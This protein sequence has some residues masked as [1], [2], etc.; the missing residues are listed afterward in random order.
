MRHSF[1]KQVLART[2]RNEP[3]S[4]N[5]SSRTCV[6]THVSYV[7]LDF[8]DGVQGKGAVALPLPSDLEAV[9]AATTMPDAL[10]SS[11]SAV[12]GSIVQQL[13]RS[14]R[15]LGSLP[16]CGSESTVPCMVNLSVA[17]RAR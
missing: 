12:G 5:Y 4:T 15:S 17:S 10:F 6:K 11:D 14:G 9:L 16:N 1:P 13:R 2:V 8:G 7:E 3:D